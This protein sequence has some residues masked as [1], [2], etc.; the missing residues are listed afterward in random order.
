MRA[1]KLKTRRYKVRRASGRRIWPFILLAILLAG[2]I[3]TVLSPGNQWLSFL[4]APAPTLSPQESAQATREITL[5]GGTWYALQLGVFEKAT[6]AEEM[7]ATYRARGAAGYVWQHDNYRVLAAAYP[8]RADAQSVQT[9]LRTLHNVDAFTYE[10]TWAEVKLRVKGQNA[11]LT[12]LEDAY[13]YLENSMAHLYSLS[14]ALDKQ[15]MAASDVRAALASEKL[16]ADTLK[17]RLTT[18]F[19]T[20]PHA[21]VSQVCDILSDLSSALSSA[22]ETSISD[23]QLGA[24]VKNCLLL[25]LTKTS[26][27]IAALSN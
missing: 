9:Q 27:Y 4:D 2:G 5:T 18:L 6:A 26:E 1:G 23:A 14:L 8:A 19:G 22:G 15:E 24:R 10:I 12:A 17:N 3:Y 11:Q 16:T 21:A 25:T 13:A 7:A 20:N